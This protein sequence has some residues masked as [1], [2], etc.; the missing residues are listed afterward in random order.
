MRLSFSSD[1]H[2]DCCA[3]PARTFLIN[4]SFSGVRA[5][6]PVMNQE[7]A[8]QKA[9]FRTTE[10]RTLTGRVFGDLA[11]WMVGLGLAMGLLFPFATI[12]FGVPSR[13]TLRITFFAGTIAAG[14]MVSGINF[15]IA[16]RVVGGRL[17]ELSERMSH[18]SDVI[19]ES[20]IS[21]D[22]SQCTP[23]MCDLPED[24]KDELGE[25]A[26]SFNELLQALAD[27]RQIE[28]AMSEFSAALVQ[29]LELGD[30][31]ATTL[32]GFM[33]H[34]DADAG[35]IG[36][37]RD[38]DLVFELAYGLDSAGLEAS[39]ILNSAQRTSKA[40]AVTIPEG[41]VVETSLV[42]FRPSQVIL[43]PV[44]FKTVPVGVVLLACGQEVAA[45]RLRLLDNLANAS[46]VAL[47]NAITHESLERLAAVDPLTGAYNRRFGDGRLQE[48]WSRAVRANIPI[49][50]ISFDLDH[51][52]SVNDTFGHL[53]GDRVLKGVVAAA[54]VAIRQ[55]DVL[56]RT[57]GEEFLVILPGAGSADVQSVADRIRRLVAASSVPSEVG[58]LQVTVSLGGLSWPDVVADRPEDLLEKLDAALYES[59][60]HGRDR[61][62]MVNFDQSKNT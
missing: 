48:E 54:R 33:Q 58:P 45:G 4:E 35:A 49:G 26:H 51:F 6:D 21:G 23:E 42:S 50:L 61:L 5:Y 29:N 20:T 3:L 43:V 59:K 28:E 13:M 53:S 52:K 44:R 34:S 56:V 41:L 36:V 18:V 10:Q 31:A 46:G 22:W 47:N 8:R 17:G 62:T 37:V 24:S 27:S 7:S 55:G 32:S 19:T 11:L 39:A 40:S 38:G 9:R 30:V 16:H 15:V 12:V 1:W 25:A 14:L 57:G 2:R 60:E